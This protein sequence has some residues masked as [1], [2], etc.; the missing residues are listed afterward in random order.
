M[1]VV[2]RDKDILFI[3]LNIVGFLT[4]ATWLMLD[5]LVGLEG[6]P[7]CEAIPD[8]CVAVILVRAASWAFFIT[9]LFIIFLCDLWW[10][11]RMGKEAYR[12]Y[13]RE[14]L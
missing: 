14:N 1:A 6:G 8:M 13:R 11:V 12:A 2:L 10:V 9:Q 7:F 4:F 3:V 5:Y